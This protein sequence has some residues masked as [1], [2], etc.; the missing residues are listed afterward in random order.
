[1][2][3]TWSNP[4]K[5]IQGW[6]LSGALIPHFFLKMKFLLN[7]Q[8]NYKCWIKCISKKFTTTGSANTCIFFVFLKKNPTTGSS[9]FLS[10]NGQGF[11]KKNPKDNNHYGWP[12][13]N[14]DVFICFLPYYLTT[15]RPTDATTFRIAKGISQLQ[16]VVRIQA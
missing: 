10:P 11:R 16:I 1:M 7:F 8:K 13:D 2:K 12:M 9:H 14:S 6:D 3:S 5:K 15:P 4:L